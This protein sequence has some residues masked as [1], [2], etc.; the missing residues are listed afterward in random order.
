MINRIPII[1]WM[2][3]VFFH[4]SLAIPTYFLW[5]W[6]QPEYFYFV[7][8]PWATIP[9]WHCVGLLWLIGIA[10]HVFKLSFVTVSQNN[11][12]NE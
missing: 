5:K 3:S 2:I 9:F 12:N 7:P 8:E 4:F 11:K 6:F 10:K 1:G